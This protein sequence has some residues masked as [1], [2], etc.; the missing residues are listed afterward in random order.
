MYVVRA[1]VFRHGSH[2]LVWSN[3]FLL[4]KTLKVIFL[5]RSEQNTQGLLLGIFCVSEGDIRGLFHCSVSWR[6]FTAISC[7][8]V[9]YRAENGKEGI[10]VLYRGSTCIYDRKHADSLAINMLKK[11]FPV[12]EYKQFM[13]Y[14]GYATWILLFYWRNTPKRKL[15]A[16]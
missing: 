5:T 11:L 15:W 4:A 1:K 3:L 12:A 13:L 2:N 6:E 16:F 14:G 9:Q 8:L 7:I 10:P